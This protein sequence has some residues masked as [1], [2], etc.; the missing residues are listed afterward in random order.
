MSGTGSAAVR[1]GPSP[2]ES[3]RSSTWTAISTQRVRRNSSRVSGTPRG[4]TWHAAAG[5]EDLAQCRPAPG[6]GAGA[7]AGPAA[8]PVGQPLERLRRQRGDLLAA[9][10]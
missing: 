7:A 9:V 4:A 5:G 1:P 2:I 8:E 6:G 10:D 3:S